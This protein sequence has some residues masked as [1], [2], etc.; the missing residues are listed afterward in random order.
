MNLARGAA[1]LLTVSAALESPSARNVVREAWRIE[2]ALPRWFDTLPLPDLM[3]RLD[4]E[5]RVQPLSLDVARVTRL[6]DAVVMLDYFS[7]LGICLR[8]SL[9]RY[10]LLRRAG[11]PVVV[12]F[13]AKQNSRDG[14]STIAG[15]AWL[16]RD[17]A[18]YAENP[19]DYQGFTAIYTYP[20]SNSQPPTP[21]LQPTS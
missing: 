14:H 6:T 19:A 10:V 1:N 16:T 4:A 7:P 9:V 2:R 21:N 18:P 3:Q 13:G 17:G 8:R 12:H 20:T 5:A 15:H 11:V